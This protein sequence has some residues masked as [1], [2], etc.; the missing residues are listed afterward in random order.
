MK[1][2]KLAEGVYRIY[3]DIGNRDLFE[4]IW[5]LPHGVNINS[6]IVQGEDKLA[7]ID[8]V[9]D[10]EGALEK[11]NS[12]LA[13]LGYSFNDVDYLVL[14]HM[15]P[16]HTG[17]LADMVARNPHMEI[18][19]TKKAVPLVSSFYNVEKNVRAVSSGDTVDLGGKTLVFTE[20]PNIHWPETMMTFVPEDHILFSCDAFGSFGT[21]EHG[22]DDEL[23]QKEWDLLIPE[24]QRYYANIVSSFSQFVTRGIEKLSG[25]DIK[26]VAPSHGI[27]WRENPQKVIDLYSSYA[28]WMNNPPSDTVTI[29][30]SSMYG[31]SIKLIPAIKKVL[32][33]EGLNVLMHEVPKEHSS[34]VL[35]SAW[36]SGA[37]VMAMPTYEYRM[38]PP[39]YHILDILE[40]SHVNRRKVM[41]IGSYGWS[42]GAQKQF[43]PIVASLKW[44]CLGTVEY[45]GAPFEE[46][47]HK[48]VETARA[49]ALSLKESENQ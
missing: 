31:N 2:N 40:R 18:L 30:Y 8:L 10:W 44:E 24:T 48:A 42:G 49:L 17:A 21:Y 22:F 13:S 47:E 25:F 28:Q 35:S 14:N 5:P 36:G 41:R 4:G 15:E 16:D 6:Y 9:K 32:E 20:T 45:Q 1:P 27:V 34:F 26:I 43:D 46:D 33:E 12:Q 37:L 39:M 19:C 11:V 3:A 7:F 23:T 29:I 38:F